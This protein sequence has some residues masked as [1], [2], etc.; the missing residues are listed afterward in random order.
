MQAAT[1]ALWWA[2]SLRLGDLYFSFH[3]LTIV[4][5]ILSGL[6]SNISLL[7]CDAVKQNTA[8]ADVRYH[9][10]PPHTFVLQKFK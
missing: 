7:F 5:V 4:V 8:T 2:S 3:W 9:F 6:Q 10:T 1:T